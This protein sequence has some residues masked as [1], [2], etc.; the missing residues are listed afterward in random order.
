[1]GRSLARVS[2]EGE[3]ELFGDHPAD[4]K[5]PFQVDPL[6]DMA[7]QD[8]LD[9]A[10]APSPTN[11]NVPSRSGPRCINGELVRPQ[12]P[13][14]DSPST[15]RNTSSV[16]ASGGVRLGKA[17]P[18]CFAAPPG[19]SQVPSRRLPPPP[20]P[21][22]SRCSSNAVPDATVYPMQWTPLHTRPKSAGGGPPDGSGDG[23]TGSAGGDPSNPSGNA[24]PGGGG[25]AGSST[26]GGGD[27]PGG[28]PPNGNPGNGNSAP[29]PTPPGSTPPQQTGGAGQ[30][31]GHPTPPAPP[32][33]TPPGQRP[34]DP[35]TSLHR[36][37]KPLPK[38]SL[39]SN[40]K[41]CSIL[42]M[43]QMLKVWYDRST[44]A[45]AT[46]RGELKDIGLLKFSN[47]A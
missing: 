1:M 29:P 6:H 25:S 3:C 37:R 40:Y 31:G 30:P 20:P 14:D 7:R 8:E 18:P 43:Q 24:H 10:A 9:V 46:W 42:D 19:I 16:S 11:A 21:P 4:E 23:G 26:S 34:V 32:P 39:P 27:P 2:R 36:S 33:P 12:P 13:R 38:L 28:G 5:E 44:F 22:S 45:I 17:R 35:W 47:Q 15:A 41:N